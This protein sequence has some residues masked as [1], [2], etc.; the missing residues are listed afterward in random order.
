M[1][2][3]NCSSVIR[4]APRLVAGAPMCSQ[5]CH[6]CF[7]TCCQRSQVLKGAPNVVSSTPRCSQ[8][9]HNH[10]HGTPVQVIIDPSY[11][12]GRLECPP[13]VWYSPQLMLLSWHSTS[14]QTLLEASRDY[15]T[16]CW[17]MLTSM[18]IWPRW[19]QPGCSRSCIA[20]MCE[21]GF[22]GSSGFDFAGRGA[23]GNAVSSTSGLAGMEE[24]YFTRNSNKID[25]RRFDLSYH[26]RPRFEWGSGIG[27]VPS[28]GYG[29]A[30]R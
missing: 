24:L 13:G 22:T 21:T 9:Y 18:S 20:G 4:G 23:T 12:K 19:V 26:S 28:W 10:S 6:W 30:E 29:F 17:Y 2:F 25:K 27:I 3:S 8:T 11:S 5:T 15:N 14:S 16:F 7:Q 1:F